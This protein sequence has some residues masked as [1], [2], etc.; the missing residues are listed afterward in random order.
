[1]GL[2]LAIVD[3]LVRQQAGAVYVESEG[4]GKGATFIVEFPLSSSEVI[5]SDLGRVDL[6]SD[7]ARAMLENSEIC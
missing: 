7:H 3:Y 2:G 6:F 5:T 1:M 4:P